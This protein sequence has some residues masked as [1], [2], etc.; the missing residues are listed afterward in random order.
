MQLGITCKKSLTVATLSCLIPLSWGLKGTSNTFT[1]MHIN[2]D[3]FNSFLQVLYG[4]KVW[5]VYCEKPE[6]HVLL[7]KIF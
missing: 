1:F 6:L 4:K 2:I 3:G 5:I 7:L